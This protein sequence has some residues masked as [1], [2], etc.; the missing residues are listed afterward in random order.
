[1]YFFFQHWYSV[2]GDHLAKHSEEN[3]IRSHLDN[4]LG[5][6]DSLM[7]IDGEEPTKEMILVR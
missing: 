7:M 4:L 2:L 3:R 5:T 1:M 6:P